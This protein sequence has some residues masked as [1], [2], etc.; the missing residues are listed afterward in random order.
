MKFQQKFINAHLPGPSLH[1]NF[2]VTR[3]CSYLSLNSVRVANSDNRVF[4]R[5][6]ICRPFTVK[7]VIW[8]AHSTSAASDMQRIIQMYSTPLTKSLP[9]WLYSVVIDAFTILICKP[10]SQCPESTHRW[11]GKLREESQ[12][13]QT[14]IAD[15]CPVFD[16]AGR[17]SGGTKAS[18]PFSPV[19]WK[20]P[21]DMH[22]EASDFT[23]RCLLI[24][25]LLKTNSTPVI[26]ENTPL[27]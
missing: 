17:S 27:F 8:Q 2:R 25:F 15:L 21:N 23:S 13:L 22:V 14:F 7:G 10:F 11:T 12:E 18:H 19:R 26:F 1:R 24:N 9:P 6:L 3:I 20:Q 5:I 16:R 4:E